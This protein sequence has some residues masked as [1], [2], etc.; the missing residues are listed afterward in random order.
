[1]IFLAL[2]IHFRFSEEIIRKTY[3]YNEVIAFVFILISMVGI[4]IFFLS[5]KFRIIG[6]GAIFLSVSCVTFFVFYLNSSFASKGEYESFKLRSANWTDNGFFLNIEVNERDNFTK[7]TQ[8]K[9]LKIDSVKVRIDEGLFGMKTITDDVIIEENLNCE[10]QDLDSTNLSKSHLKIG[11]DLATRRC[12]TSAIYHYSFCIELDSLN[13]D[14]YY[15]RGLMYMAK[16][17]YELALI[18]FLNAA[19]IKYNSLNINTID[20]LNQIDLS[21]YTKRIFNKF[22]NNEFDEAV[23]FIE[24]TNTIESFDTYQ[25]QIIFCMEKINKDI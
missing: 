2:L 9:C 8:E 5:K 1:M 17:N 15:K 3:A 14:I 13:L 11:D 21:S 24:T 12:F 10:H 25:K 16:K 6:I 20:S 7:V 22:K 23:S 4:I 19:M 18:D